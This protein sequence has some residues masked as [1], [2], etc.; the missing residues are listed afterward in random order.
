MKYYSKNKV[1]FSKLILK[2]IITI[3]NRKEKLLL[4]P[5]YLDSPM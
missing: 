3:L 4:L 1:R 5:Q 2:L